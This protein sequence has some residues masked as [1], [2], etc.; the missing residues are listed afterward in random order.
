MVYLQICIEF[1]DYLLKNYGVVINIGF[2]SSI[3]INFPNNTYVNRW[4][5]P[6]MEILCACHSFLSKTMLPNLLGMNY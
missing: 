2:S 6:Y 1:R 5:F 3:S 4:L